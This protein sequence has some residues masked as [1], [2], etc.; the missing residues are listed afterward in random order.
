MATR[1]SA[2]R[3]QLIVEIVREQRTATV[4]ELSERLGVSEATIRR[5]LEK[6]TNDGSVQ[7]AHGGALAPHE[8]EPEPPVLRRVG[9]NAEQ[10][11]RIGHAAAALIADGDTVFIGSGTTTVELARHLGGRRD[12]KV[13]T[14]ALNVA[15]VL[16]AMPEITTILVGGVLRHSEMSMIGHLAEQ[17][18]ADL[19]A[20]KVVM[21]IRAL[22]VERG[23]S[24]ELGVETSMDRAIVRCA[25]T[26]IVLADHSKLAKAASVTI[27]PLAAVH[28][29]VTDAQAPAE[30]VEAIQAHG[31]RVL[32]A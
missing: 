14:N 15:N 10:K 13:I 11:R 25:P 24:N 27:A 2:E 28:T 18:L 5:D 22:S 3:Q 4:E 1:L 26:L 9:D 19:S 23:L 12:L 20:T 6:L 32:L 7:R 17:A 29:L 30:A 16:A 8:A 21:G 31:V